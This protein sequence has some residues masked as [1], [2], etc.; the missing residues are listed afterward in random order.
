MIAL[1]NLFKQDIPTYFNNK[2]IR[3]SNSNG[4]FFI[5]NKDFCKKM[6][7]FSKTPIIFQQYML[8]Y[9]CYILY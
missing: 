4:K 7:N 2:S 9:I 5:F 3:A 1:K 6:K 8:N